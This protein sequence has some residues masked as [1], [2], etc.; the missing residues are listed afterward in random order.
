L[1]PISNIIESAAGKGSLLDNAGQ[2]FGLWLQLTLT[3]DRIAVPVKI[4]EIEFFEPMQDQQGIFECTCVLTEMNEEFATAN[5]IMKRNGRVWAIISGWQNRRLEIDEPLWNVS[6]S[7][8]NNR[9]SEEI[10]PGVFM[11]HQA[12]SRVVSWDFILKRYFNQ[13]EKNIIT[14]YRLVKEKPGSLAV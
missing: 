11:F 2:L 9:L 10:A 12:Y 3:K 1:W 7:P 13:D 6:M 4:Q 14:A 8:L 5:I